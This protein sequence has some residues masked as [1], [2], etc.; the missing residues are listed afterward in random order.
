MIFLLIALTTTAPAP[1]H[2]QVPCWLVKSYITMVGEEAARKLGRKHGYT[3]V[4]I[5]AVKA[6]CFKNG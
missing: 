4:E 5:D 2:H 1:K 3:E 6:R